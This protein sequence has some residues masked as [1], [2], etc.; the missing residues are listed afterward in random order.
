[1]VERK[2]LILKWLE[3]FERSGLSA[4]AFFAKYRVPFS[5]VQFYRY[6]KSILQSGTDSLTDGRSGG[7]HRHVHSEA[8]GFLVGYVSAH[9][10]ATESELQRVMQERFGIEI[11]QSG[12]SQCLKRLGIRRPWPRP[13]AQPL[14]VPAVYAGFELVVAL[15]WHFGWPQRTAE[16]IGQAIARAQR[17]KRFAAPDEAADVKGRSQRGQFTARYNR[18][19]PV[20]LQRFQSVEDKRSSKSLQSMDV[21][22]V[23]AQTL[24]RKCLGVLTLP[25][26]TG[27]GEVRTVNTALGQSLQAF[28][29]FQYKQATLARFLAELKYLGVA[30][31]LLH[32]QVAFWQQVW[33]EELPVEENFPL[34][35]YYVDGHTK[36][37]WSKKR[38]KKNKV[39]MLGR[40]MGCLEQV[41]VHDS[42]GRP[43]YFETYSGHAPMGEYIL[44]LF[45]KIEDSLEGGGPK[46]AVQRAIVMDAASNSV[47]T[48]RAFACQK[49]Y[50][51]ITSLDDNQWD[52]RKIRKQGKPQR[53]RHGAATL[54]ECEIELE[55]SREK[56]Y[57]FVT[58]AIKI[59][60]D[61]GKE[62]YLIT[63]LPKDIVGASQVVKAYFDR[64]PDEELPFKVMKAVGCLN[65]VAGYGKQKLPDK[66]V[67]K[68]QRQLAC[69]IQAL[70]QKLS[71]PQAA[72]EKEE[73]RIATLI[74]QERR[75]RAR[76]RIVEG[77]RVLPCR[78]T[79]E[80]KAISCRIAGHQRRIKAIR[81]A[82]SAFKKLERLQ[83]EWMRLQG[84][85]TVYKV[86]VELDQIMTYF[87]VSLVNLYSY[88]ARMLGWSHL[89]L[90]KFLYT[91]LFLTGKVEETP[92]TRHV[93]LERNEKDP[94]T[95]EVLG[96]AL[97]VI[98]DLNIHNIAGQKLT[99]ALE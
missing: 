47:R 91:V 35:C 46:L 5:L 10:S 85:E 41:F 97:G 3:R 50:H 29:G 26:V 90:V 34:L 70:K 42:H 63:S 95:M 8:E 43:L 60:R 65:R 28:C 76:S 31:D 98:N 80:L 45:E 9:P 19:R 87:R 48:L 64:W 72:I 54:W 73:S 89:S 74:P 13:R 81:K 68:R 12:M 33:R 6:R 18:R 52:P 32:D 59:V 84:K 86:D 17:S 56:D 37:L 57:L 7:N 79:Q 99:F 71:E 4:P 62:T 2:E 14:R 1:M 38:V 77:R 21:A 15:A 83:R 69:Q 11:S 27:N 23:K 24:A 25:F 36:A 40:V 92:G 53:Y 16:V 96:K 66:E 78:E 88:L 20:R 93:I 61:R 82:N 75:L 22:K 58:R 30:E 39:T 67:E 94:Q 51:Y 55:D 49:K 44:S